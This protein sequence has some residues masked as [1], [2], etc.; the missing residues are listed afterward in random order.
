MLLCK[1][2]F[3]PAYSGVL[4]CICFG[5]LSL[6]ESKRRP[7]AT[8]I[9]PHPLALERPRHQFFLVRNIFAISAKRM[10]YPDSFSYYA[11]ASGC[12]AR[13][14]YVTRLSSTQR[15]YPQ[16]KLHNHIILGSEMVCVSAVF[17]TACDNLFDI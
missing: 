11:H 8:R 9:H 4:G 3:Y 5:D 7:H 13:N 12:R 10:N 2:S 14:I 16:K 15:A 6:T 17:V 1:R